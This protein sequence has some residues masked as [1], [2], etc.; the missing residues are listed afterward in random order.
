MIV[1]FVSPEAEAA[2]REFKR[3]HHEA[4][5]LLTLLRVASTPQEFTQA[6][7]P[8]IEDQG[9]GLYHFHFKGLAILPIQVVLGWGYAKLQLGMITRVEAEHV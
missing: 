9:K 5:I 1:E 7:K 2:F 8:A 6:L 4:V 3:Q